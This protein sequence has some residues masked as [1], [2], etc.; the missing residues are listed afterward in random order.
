MQFQSS[1]LIS[2]NNKLRISQKVLNLQNKN[3]DLIADLG[4]VDLR[5]L[6]TTVCLRS[7]M[8]VHIRGLE[9]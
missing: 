1:Y 2:C 5:A 3:D 4:E 8:Q 6:S 9:L 7:V